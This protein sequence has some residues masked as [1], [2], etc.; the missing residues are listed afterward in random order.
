V[1][2]DELDAWS[3]TA[4]PREAEL[5]RVDVQVD[6]D[7]TDELRGLLRDAVTSTSLGG[8]DFFAGASPAW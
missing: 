5:R 7:D 3:G 2:H 1:A 4:G 8:T 6:R